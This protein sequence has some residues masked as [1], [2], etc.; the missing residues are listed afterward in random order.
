M[1]P[2]FAQHVLEFEAPDDS[3]CS[4]LVIRTES[5][6]RVVGPTAY[7]DV[8]WLARAIACH[9]ADS[10]LS[11]AGGIWLTSVPASRT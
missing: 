5:E 9:P 2:A 11:M 7:S 1:Y 10:T 3:Q 4:A 8:S 6:G